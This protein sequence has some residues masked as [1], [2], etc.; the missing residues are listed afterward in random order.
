VPDKL[1]PR[2]RDTAL[3]LWKVYALFTVAETLLLMAGG[4]TFF[5]ALN[6]AFTTM[7]T[8]G[9]STKNAS[10]AHFDS[11]YIDVVIT[12]FMLLAG[13]NFS[14]HYQ[15]LK[16]PP[17]GILE[18]FGMP[19]L[20]GHVPD[21]DPCGRVQ[22]LPHGLSGCRSGPALRRLSGGLHRDHHRVRD[23]RL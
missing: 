10:V 19:V 22:R 11:V 14:L 15:L 13:I 20:P 3:I 6:H 12:V 8:G 7:P 1:K 4:M 16:G 9:F 2:I 17:A 18:R 21:P 5:D 23:G